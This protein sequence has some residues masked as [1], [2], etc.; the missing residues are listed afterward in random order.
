MITIPAAPALAAIPFSR[1]LHVEWRKSTDTRASRWLLV[2]VL[3]TSVISAAIPL[4]R[5]HDA[6]Q[7]LPNYLRTV[8]LGVTILLPVVS[9]LTLTSEWGQ[10]TV[11]TT[12]TQQP[13]RQQ[14][15]AAKLGAGLGLAAAGAVAGLAVTAGA[16]QLSS[17]LGRDVSW[18]ITPGE[19]AGYA[20]FVVLNSVMGMAFGALFHNTAA[21]VVTFFAL[22]TLM[23]VIAM[24]IASIR[25]WVDP[26]TTLTWI[27]HGEWS[28]HTA[29]I[30]TSLAVWLAIPLAAGLTRTL[31][32]E[33]H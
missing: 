15:L 31:R 14:V 26:T 10:R 32:R 17:M 22:P 3:C 30:L 24:P 27:L 25:E 4:V 19:L 6:I 33:I 16:L 18:H 20:L 23:T 5:P 8:A 1:S 28:G 12:F 29:P 21:A 9:I 11:L 13:R 2:S 7:D